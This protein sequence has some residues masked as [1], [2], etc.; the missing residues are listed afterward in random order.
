MITLNEYLEIQ[1]L[2]RQGLSKSE[3]ARRLDIERI[4]G[5]AVYDSLVEGG[6]YKAP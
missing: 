6:Y 4:P 5:V 1:Q 3:I 2:V